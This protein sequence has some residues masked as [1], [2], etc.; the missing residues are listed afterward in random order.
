MMNTFNLNDK[1]Y[2]ITTSVIY[3]LCI[4]VHHTFY[5]LANIVFDIR[6]NALTLP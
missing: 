6:N 1:K 5:H 3:K 2:E 4:C